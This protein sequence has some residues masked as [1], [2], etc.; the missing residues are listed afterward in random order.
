MNQDS[1][2]FNHKHILCDNSILEEMINS[3]NFL[4]YI[5]GSC[6]EKKM[7]KDINILIVY[8]NLNSYEKEL[9]KI[10]NNESVS[11]IP[12]HCTYLTQ[13]EFNE[14]SNYFKKTKPNMVRIK[15]I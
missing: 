6:L 15:N 10:L 14:D 13:E 1:W 5:F 4:I 12:F 3:E 8:K 9:I 7:P 11:E 2:F